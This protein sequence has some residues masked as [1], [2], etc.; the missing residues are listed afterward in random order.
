M[1][2]YAVGARVTL[3]T[4]VTATPRVSR[5]HLR[6]QQQNRDIES[7][8]RTKWLTIHQTGGPPDTYMP[9]VVLGEPMRA[10]GIVQVIESRH[11]KFKPGDIVNYMAISGIVNG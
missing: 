11:A 8:H 4:A 6:E 10:I 2:K 3:S 5:G 9:A 1:D 7:R